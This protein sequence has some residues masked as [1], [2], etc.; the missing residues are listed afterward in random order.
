[1]T[2]EAGLCWGLSTVMASRL[3]PGLHDAS[4][5][6][7]VKLSSATR[8]SPPAG[9]PKPTRALLLTKLC[10]TTVRRPLATDTSSSRTACAPSAESLLKPSWSARRRSSGLKAAL[11]TELDAGSR[12]DSGRP[13]ARFSTCTRQHAVQ[14]GTQATWLA[15]AAITPSKERPAFAV[16]GS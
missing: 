12:T 4:C 5:T 7:V 16:T 14:S 9:H 1:M 11:A 10:G 13:A 3:A 6:L 2:R 15:L 8:L